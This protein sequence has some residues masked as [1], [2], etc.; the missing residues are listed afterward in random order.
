M[1]QRGRVGLVSRVGLVGAQRKN[2]F[3]RTYVTYLTY[4]TSPTYLIYLTKSAGGQTRTV[5]PALMRRVL[6]PTELL[7]P[8][9]LMLTR[10]SRPKGL[11]Y[12]CSADLSISRRYMCSA[13]LQV[14]HHVPAASMIAAANNGIMIS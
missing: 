2:D 7:R 9:L 11:H 1:G 13:D 12:R 8:E 10:R 14:R 3:V 4:L 5:D 6:S